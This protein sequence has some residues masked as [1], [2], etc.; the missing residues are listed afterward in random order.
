MT[1]E[2]AAR[3]DE[4]ERV[5][6]WDAAYV[7]GALSPEDRR[8]FERHLRTCDRCTA[9]VAELAGIPPLLGLV[10]RG[11]VADLRGSSTPAAAAD[12]RPDRTAAGPDQAAAGPG[13][14]DGQPPLA[15]VVDLAAVVRTARAR[16]R[17]RGVWLA[18]AAAGVLLVGG[19]AGYAI[20]AAGSGS[21]PAAVSAAGTS[22]D[23]APVGG[24]GVTASLRFEPKGWGTH[25]SWSCA[26][27]ATA[28]GSPGAGYPGASPGTGAGTAA[29][30]VTYEL[31]VVDAEGHATQVATW[32]GGGSGASGLGASSSVPA[33]SIRSIEIRQVGATGALAAATV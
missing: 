31:V 20:S 21:A 24:S 22:V 28:Q 3:L 29:G 8:D 4:H 15:D 1:D 25:F 32:K 9:A 7:L 17:R 27:P 30:T 6:E 2:T 26:Y 18:A 16:G 19:G 14:G 5:A 10:P 12:V 11:A 33:S 13:P 23:L